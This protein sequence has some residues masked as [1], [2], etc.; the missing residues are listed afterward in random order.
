M[1]KLTIGLIILICIPIG[2]IG[3]HRIAYATEY[4]RI[5]VLNAEIYKLQTNILEYKPVV[6]LT[7]TE[8]ASKAQWE[9]ADAYF[10]K[11]SPHARVVEA[12]KANGVI[13][14]KP[15][16][17]KEEPKIAPVFNNLYEFNNAKLQCKKDIIELEYLQN[18]VKYLK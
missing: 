13:S 12:N 2:Y 6:E 9:E 3:I 18:T 17:P 10:P 14:P 16:V 7:A 8:I 4:K 5:N 1:K 11:D 15:M